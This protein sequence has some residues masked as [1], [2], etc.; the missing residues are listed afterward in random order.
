V[1]IAEEARDFFEK[2]LIQDPAKRLGS[3]GVESIKA[4]PFFCG[5]DWD[6]LLSKPMDLFIPNP[7]N[8]SDTSY[9]WGSLRFFVIY[10]GK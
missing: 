3:D 5:I 7:A 9:H 10:S 4:R 1:F 2:L 6:T 8:Q